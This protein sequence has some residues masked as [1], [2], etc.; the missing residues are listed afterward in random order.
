MDIDFPGVHLGAASTFQKPENSI[1]WIV[2]GDDKAVWRN[3]Q[4]SIVIGRRLMGIS[5]HPHSPALRL[6]ILSFN[7]Q[8]FGPLFDFLSAWDDE[9]ATM[10]HISSSRK[11][12]MSSQA[13]QS[14]IALTCKRVSRT[15]GVYC[16]VRRA[17]ATCNQ[18]PLLIAL[19]YSFD[20]K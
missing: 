7:L 13:T 12:T 15:H 10:F 8:I 9:N 3:Y 4:I 6:E 2:R 19:R 14:A 11:R 5:D 16:V 1:N 18:S 17:L 20:K